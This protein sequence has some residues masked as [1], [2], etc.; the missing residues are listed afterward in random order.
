MAVAKHFHINER[1]IANYELRDL[2]LRYDRARC[3]WVM[4]DN[5]KGNYAYCGK[6]KMR[7]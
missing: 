1:M 7:P 3:E 4:H 2:A 6:R 5:R